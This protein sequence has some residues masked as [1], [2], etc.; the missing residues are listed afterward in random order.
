MPAIE[1]GSVTALIKGIIDDA[2]VLFKQQLDLVKHEFRDDVRKMGNAGSIWGAG[3]AA[4]AVGGVML[5]NMFAHLFSTLWP[6]LPLWGS[7][8]IVAAVLF[9]ISGSLF[10]WGKAQFDSLRL[11]PVK[12]AQALEENMQCI[13]HPTTMPR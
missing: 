2:Q 6:Q 9:V 4:A 8:G 3:I 5:A 7:Y 11:L 10:W 1:N 12:S 13:T